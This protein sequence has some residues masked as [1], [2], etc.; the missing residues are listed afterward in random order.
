M[1]RSDSYLA[2]K[3]RAEVFG[4]LRGV[5]AIFGTG[6]RAVCAGLASHCLEPWGIANRRIYS[7]KFFL[8]VDHKSTIPAGV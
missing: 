3:P 5:A 2:S 4:G 8:A 7:V 6:S 1:T